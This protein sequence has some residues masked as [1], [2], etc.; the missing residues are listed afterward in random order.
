MYKGG[1]VHVQNSCFADKTYYFFGVLSTV[2]VVG[3]VSFLL[4]IVEYNKNTG[5]VAMN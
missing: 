5:K 3:F 4:L 2:R 1:V